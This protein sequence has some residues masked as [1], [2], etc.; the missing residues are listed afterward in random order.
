M[1]IRQGMKWAALAAAGVALSGCVAAQPIGYADGY[2]QPV[3]SDAAPAYGE[4]VYAD[5]APA[6]YDA[7]QSATYY[8]PVYVEPYYAP[9]YPTVGTSVF[10]NVYNDRSYRKKGRNYRADRRAERRE[11]RRL[12]RAEGNGQENLT[13]AERQARRVERRA[14]RQN[15][16][17]EERQALRAER[18]AERQEQRRIRQANAQNGNPNPRKR[19]I[20]PANTERSPV[21][22]IWKLSRDSSNN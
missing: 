10:Y 12:R 22:N 11:R 21:Q 17:R 7:G 14:E 18:R 8:E 13:R 19:I 4:P 1:S 2:G 3:Y 15:L 9:A 20:I 6:Y 5:G 16:T